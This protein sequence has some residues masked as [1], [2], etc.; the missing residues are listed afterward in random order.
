MFAQAV[1][2][3]AGPAPHPS[4]RD[5][6]RATRLSEHQGGSLTDTSLKRVRVV[7]RSRSDVTAA[8]DD[9]DLRRDLTLHP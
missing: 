8:G 9:D 1:A 7:T 3:R 4:R 2:S 5:T 6:R